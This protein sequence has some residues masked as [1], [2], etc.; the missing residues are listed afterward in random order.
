MVPPIYVP[1]RGYLLTTTYGSISNSAMSTS[2][3]A[4]S[5]DGGKRHVFPEKA[6]DSSLSYEL[7]T[8]PWPSDPSEDWDPY[9]SSDDDTVFDSYDTDVERHYLVFEDEPTAM[10]TFSANIA[11]FVGGPLV[12]IIIFVMMLYIMVDFVHGDVRAFAQSQFGV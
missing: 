9:D 4:V 1:P 3:F 8:S 12:L 11:I 6:A 2:Y 7:T 5:S 10:S